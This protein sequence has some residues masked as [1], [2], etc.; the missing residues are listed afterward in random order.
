MDNKENITEYLGFDMN[1]PDRVNGEN[2]W[3]RVNVY[4]LNE[5]DI[6]R[7]TFIISPSQLRSYISSCSYKEYDEGNKKMI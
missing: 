6:Y 5:L 3:F 1:K 7:R 2:I 4:Q